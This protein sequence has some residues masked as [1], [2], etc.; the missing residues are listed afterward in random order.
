MATSVAGLSGP[1][2]NPDLLRKN[3]LMAVDYFDKTPEITY[4]KDLAGMVK[5]SDQ[6]NE[7]IAA[8]SGLALP[9]VTGEY[10]VAP[11]DDITSPA[12]KVYTPQK[13]MLQ[14]RMSD[15][16]FINDQYGVVKG[17]GTELAGV[18]ATAKEIAAAVYLNGALNTSIISTPL[19][20]AL[21]SASQPLA[22]G[23]DSNTFTT[24]QTLGIIALEDA[25][26]LL[27]NQQAHKN[28]PMPKYG[29]FQLEVATRNAKLAERLTTAGQLP[30]T[31]N[32]DKNVVAGKIGRVIASPYFTNPEWWCL[33]S[34]NPAKQS[35][36]CLTRY[37]FK[38]TEL[39]YDGD[40][41]SWKVTAKESYLFDVV[42][43]RGA[44]YS[45]PS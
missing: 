18:F 16:A 33:R 3:L 4:W 44:F 11:Q 1:T 26:N 40:T 29:P 24:Q 23:F 31:N 25:T 19:G 45:T 39:V 27:L 43:Y 34:M 15:E 21:S 14:F 41:D 37:G 30:T 9:Q 36:F 12:R 22:M 2:A 13:R 6:L 17:Y 42:D 10:G 38:L 20:A 8:V 7:I 32:N 35:R 5:P 28:Y